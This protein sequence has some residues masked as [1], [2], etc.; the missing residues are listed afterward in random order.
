M[1]RYVWIVSKVDGPWVDRVVSD[2]SD[3][4]QALLNA[5]IQALLH[6]RGNVLI[7][8]L[9]GFSKVRAEFL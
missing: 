4:V 8:V 9:P 3:D 5:R 6:K 2:D 7:D 1:D